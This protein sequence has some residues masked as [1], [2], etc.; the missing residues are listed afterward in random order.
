MKSS[1]NRSALPW[2][3]AGLVC[4]AAICARQ[5]LI[6]PPE[7]AHRCVSETLTLAVDGPWWCGVRAALIMT[8]AKWN[9]LLVGSGVL[10]VLALVT[11]R[12]AIGWLA[13]VVG[14]VA[15]VFYTYEAGAVAIAVGAL[16]LARAQAGP[17]VRPA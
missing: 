2:I 1:P 10:A 8:Y 14:L 3:V 9:P 15:I 6:Q 12:G 7:I 13:L 5:F 16:V 11:R 4:L 17:I